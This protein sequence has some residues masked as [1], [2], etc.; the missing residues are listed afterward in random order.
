MW[1]EWFKRDRKSLGIANSKFSIML[2]ETERV[3]SN[4]DR[5]LKFRF[6]KQVGSLEL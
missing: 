3:S 4:L 6:E 5:I 1:P 2:K